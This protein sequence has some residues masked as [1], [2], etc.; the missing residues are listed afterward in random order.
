MY[1]IAG[2]K[3]NPNTELIFQFMHTFIGILQSYFHGE[4]S[5]SVIKKNFDVIY[6]LLDQTIDYGV[7]QLTEIDLLKE[8]IHAGVTP[9]A[10]NDIGEQ[11][12]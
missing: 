7:P 12:S 4:I 11:F 5:H 1:L 6:E 2:T 9:K 10:L 8:F 3:S